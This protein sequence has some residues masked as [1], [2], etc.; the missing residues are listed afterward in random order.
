[1]LDVICSCKDTIRINGEEIPHEVVK[2]HFLKLN[3]GHIRYILQS[4]SQNNSKVKNIR[5]YLLTSLYNA[6]L[7]MNNYYAATFHADLFGG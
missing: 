5:V 7:T 3:E 1:M 2:S 6:P 4:V